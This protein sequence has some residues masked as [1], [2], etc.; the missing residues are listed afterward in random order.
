MDN[1]RPGR[2]KSR[3]GRMQSHVIVPMPE[4]MRSELESWVVEHGFTSLAAGVREG[5]IRP[6]LRG[7]PGRGR[8]R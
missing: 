8:A 4:A 1:Y 7:G 3:L 2:G 6:A 5:L